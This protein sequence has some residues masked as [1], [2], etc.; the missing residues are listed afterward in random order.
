[1]PL[2]ERL[3]VISEQEYLQDYDNDPLQKYELI[4]GVIYAQAGASRNH[5]K[6][7]LNTAAQLQQYLKDNPCQPFISDL[8]VK[9]EQNYFYPDVVVDCGDDEYMADKP[10][11]IMEILSKTTAFLDKTKKLWE[12]A[13]IPTL[14]EYATIAQDEKKITLYRRDND[15]QGETITVGMVEFKSIDIKISVDEIYQGIF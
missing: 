15:W 14:Q 12:Y 7:A 9:V 4:D 8:K 6:I 13:K 10:V 5:N 2:A 11:L 1:M 3:S